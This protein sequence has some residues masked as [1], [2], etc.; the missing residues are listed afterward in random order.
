MSELLPPRQAARLRRGLLD[1]LTTTFALADGDAQAAL[2][3]FLADPVDGLFKGP[4]LRTSLPFRPAPARA[5]GLEW[6]PPGFHP[7]GHQA[8]AFGRLSSAHDRPQPTLVTTGTGSGKTEAFLYPI[9]DHVLRARRAGVHGMKALIL[10]PMNALAN[11]QAARLAALISSRPANGSR[12]PLAQVTAAIYT[13]DQTHR[14]TR[15]S[16]DGLISDRGI[17]R[18]DA[19]D[20]LLTNYKMLDQLL[21][22]ADDQPLWAASAESLQY[23]VLD[24][25]HSYD[26][27]QGTD[28][29]MLIR[30]LGLTLKSYWPARGTPD[31]QHSPE[32]W[33]RP[34]GRVT[35]VGTSAT[36][37]GGSAEGMAKIV[38]FAT[39][40]FGEHVDESCVVTESRISLDEWC[41][42]AG[43][44]VASRGL[45]PLTLT[46][47]TAAH[48]HAAVE[49]QHDAG[50][51]CRQVLAR[52][53]E[54]ADAVTSDAGIDLSG[55]D[56]GELL[57]LA[58]AHPL[59][60]ELVRNTQQAL[61]VDELADALFPGEE[62]VGQAH[63]ARAEFLLDLCSA[64]AALRA[65]PDREAVGTETHLWVRELT[66]IDRDAT[67]G[68]QYRWSD[69]GTLTPGPG[70]ESTAASHATFPAVYCRRCGRS[71]WGVQL[72]TTGND[73]ARDDHGIRAGHASGS[74]CFRAL[75]AATREAEHAPG[76]ERDPR[77][78]W[79][80]TDKRCF[81]SEPPD[82][83]DPDEREG[84]VVP[85][86]MLTGQHADEDSHADV[87]PSCGQRDAIRFLGSA[88]ATMLSV[89]LSN[90]FGSPD[91]ETADKKALVFADSVQDAAH[92][93]GFVSARSHT[94]TFRAVLRAAADG[95][96][97]IDL[98]ALVEEVLSGSRHDRFDRYRLVPAELASLPGVER[99][100][101]RGAWSSIPRGIVAA[102][103]RRLLF[104]AIMEFG[105]AGRFGR[106]LEQTGSVVAHVDAGTP[107]A[108]VAHARAAIG[109]A[110]LQETL[111]RP[112]DTVP[113]EVLVRWV[114]GVLERMRT[115]GSVHHVWLDNFVKNDG[116]RW[117][118]WGGRPRAQ[119]MPAF[120]RGRS[121]PAF[122][123]VGG[124]A[125]RSGEM[126]LDSVT[127]SQSWYAQWTRR[128][129]GIAPQ[130]G[131]RLARGL[132][133]RLATQD[134]LAQFATDSGGTVYE[135]T[136]AK[137]IVHVTRDE[138]LREG[139]HVLRCDVCRTPF[140][141][142]TETL[143]QLD[144]GPCLV[145]SCE[146]RLHPESGDPD[147]FYRGLYASH[148][149]RRVIA[150]EH[151]AM[152]PDDLRERYEK[153]F[154]DNTSNPAAPNVL[155]ATPT[156]EMG[157]DIGDLSTVFLASLPRSVASYLQRVGRAGRRTG[158]S[159]DIAFVR[160]R[161]ETLPRLG[162]PSSLI[163]GD[164]QPP[165]TYLS[166][167]EIL[168]RQYLAHVA[169]TLARDDLDSHHP[170]T[171][172]D[173]LAQDDAGSYLGG[174]VAEAE[175][176]SGEHLTAFLGCFD[177]LRP[178]AEQAL[179]SWATPD[180]GPDTSGLAAMVHR[181]CAGWQRTR[182]ELVRRRQGIEQAL[183]ELEQRA[184]SPAATED[185][186]RAHR[187]AQAAL[188]LVKGQ[189]RDSRQEYWVSALENAGLFPNYTLLDDT[190]ALDVALSW[191]NPESQSYE[192][193]P[194]NYQRSSALALREFAPGATFYA[195]GYAVE[196]DSVDLGPDAA[197][198]RPWAFCPDC[199][200][201][202]DLADS[203]AET[204]VPACPRCGSKGIS[205]VGQRLDVLE[206][207]KASAS[208]NRDECRI[209]DRSDERIRPDFTT[210]LA[211]DIDPS[212]V[213][214]RW[215][216]VGTGFGAELLNHMTLRWL[217]IG[218]RRD[219][220]QR[221]VLAGEEVRG[222]LFRVCEG[223]GHLSAPTGATNHI[224]HA[225]WCQY[226]KSP[227]RHDRAIALSRTLV[228]EGVVLPL[229]WTVTTGDEFA[230]PSLAAALLMGLRTQFG[231]SPDHI[232]VSL[233]EAPAGGDGRTRHALLLHDLVPGGTGYLAELTDPEHL[234][235][236]LRWA[237]QRVRDCPCQGEGRLACHRCLL[238]YSTPW[239]TDRVSRSSAERHLRELLGHDSDSDPDEQMRWQVVDDVVVDG[240]PPESH[241]ELR[242]RVR[243][244]AMAKD[245]GAV[246]REFP[247]PIGN[248]V[249][250]TLGEL[251]YRLQPQVDERGSKPD[252][253]LSGGG[254]P[255]VMIFTDGRDFH[256][257]VT[258]NRVSD[259]ARKRADLR[260]GGAIVLGVTMADCESTGSDQDLAPSWLDG[261]VT[262]TLMNTTSFSTEA[263]TALT[264]GPF[265]LL[266]YLVQGL[267]M[268]PLVAYSRVL[269]FYFFSG[270]VGSRELQLPK[271]HSLVRAA[272]AL[273][274]GRDPQPGNEP[275]ATEPARWWHHGAL[276]VLVRAR[277][278]MQSTPRADICVILDDR[279]KIVAGDDFEEAWRQWL[280]LSNALSVRPDGALTSIV[281]VS[282]IEDFAAD[283]ELAQP[284][285]SEE[286]VPQ[287]LSGRWRKLYEDSSPQV[288]QVV[289]ELARAGAPAPD[290]EVGEEVGPEL[291][292][293]DLIWHRQGIV[294]VVQPEPGDREALEKEGLTMAQPDAGSIMALLGDH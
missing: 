112:L 63:E 126:L 199:G 80:N 240:P 258:H 67:T 139:R 66:R 107:E 72:A 233:V 119:G 40:I 212:K 49:G 57:A 177:D 256:A 274:L 81:G 294:M 76:G 292:P 144:D 132:F 145:G 269:P 161:G 137:V 136:S 38:E 122:P 93:A 206:L 8:S 108:L 264:G 200:Y 3:D 125:R 180:D 98:D 146:G 183:G 238:P 82:P 189:L 290:G 25:F 130:W 12:N 192:T 194:V 179:R 120:P 197:D 275:A 231:G 15:V 283:E 163:N 52:M 226:R 90:L 1:Y 50:T 250:L 171:V 110:Q 135:L 124:R 278:S 227:A 94:L 254:R 291:I 175:E 162:D 165:A 251:R 56:H 214:R 86:L 129:L 116:N 198:V 46:T 249:Q 59:V 176:H 204:V 4:Y 103:R 287:L 92:N 85:V 222:P 62:L 215:S 262:A 88:V 261:R 39:R 273:I 191:L 276:G 285:A 169:D 87:C 109:S 243:F 33:D 150:R 5:E 7:Y 2:T 114:R 9:L 280:R 196:V 36:L 11:D 117:F 133:A 174:L 268:E 216:V 293:V 23:L 203:G 75:I 228:T 43:H 123:R 45:R 288:R 156:L 247:A 30:R 211:A 205:D 48:I 148:D 102:V 151:T 170:R 263:V 84:L 121:A 143:H 266:S 101:G 209:T 248:T 168:K 55:V 26:G 73:L 166:A 155:V 128:V 255:D 118:I 184:T 10:Y 14:R 265:A 154:R 167:L 79:F 115:Q 182:K 100:W 225:P 17:I 213:T 41:E 181:A 195:R 241:L 95:Q 13:G 99:F 239:L 164:V 281:T 270:D 105:L 277:G 173:A 21:L 217:N 28:V 134:V 89:T 229:P 218:K 253:V 42:G 267:P 271:G 16:A 186:R 97:W 53:Y 289:A 160:G 113:D 260:L 35:P 242:F 230:V 60:R 210:L 286:A 142:S 18:D 104:D 27:A 159:L 237:W 138:D 185:D 157:I 141:L 282:G 32:E 224:E 74:N 6:M 77:L 245:L 47:S 252:F 147:N 232:G 70:E 71:G 34:L 149:M 221:H 236:V 127:D 44:Q 279:E 272:G 29:A 220:A 61:H 193:E 64:L 178:E 201:A 208:V 187:T 172:E 190:V 24:E 78:F 244:T 58:K 37:G 188:K 106:T 284:G 131:A 69:D 158:N 51:L 19:P 54:R 153:G 140:V 111:D 235:Q 65:L 152:L 202:L 20:V 219:N 257:S 31:D 22:R 91:V 234:W 96:D 259:D 68:V 246:T 207:T 223:C 83:E